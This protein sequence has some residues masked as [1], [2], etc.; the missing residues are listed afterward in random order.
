MFSFLNNIPQVTK[1]ILLLNVLFFVLKFYFSTQGIDLDR[2][3]GA[4]YF[5]SPHFQPFQIVTHFFMHGDLMHIFLNMWLFVML[6]AHLERLWGP[7]RFFIFYIASAIGA[8]VLFNLIGVYQ[9]YEIKQHLSSSI[10]IE[11]FDNIMKNSLNIHDLIDKANTY[12]NNANVS[13]SFDMKSLETYISLANT[14]LVG[15]SGAVFGIL[16]AFAILFPNTEFLLY[17]AI[18]VKAKYLV[19]AYFVYELYKSFNGTEGDNVAHLAHVGGAIVGAIIVLYWRKTDKQ[20]F[21]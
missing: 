4:Y 14:P 13:T 18:P 6:G 12:L 21:W 2:T 20:N 19:G 10:D 1:N 7:K 5:N 11:T 17:F 3:L 9:I 16:A 8:F 15:A